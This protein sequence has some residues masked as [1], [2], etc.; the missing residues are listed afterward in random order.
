MPLPCRQCAGGLGISRKGETMTNEYQR[1]NDDG[2]E[3]SDGFGWFSDRN[4]CHQCKDERESAHLPYRWG[5]AQYSFGIYAGRY[6]RECWLKIGYRDAT[7]P[8]SNFDPTDAGERLE[9]I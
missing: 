7:H 2:L 5:D 4:L 9:E 1:E 8:N 6:C 3:F